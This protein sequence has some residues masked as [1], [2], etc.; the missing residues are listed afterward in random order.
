MEST[1][2][3]KVREYLEMNK[4]D[5]DVECSP[6]KE[7]FSDKCIQRVNGLLDGL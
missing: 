7:I 4:L 3:G 6:E 1:F 5:Q 2:S